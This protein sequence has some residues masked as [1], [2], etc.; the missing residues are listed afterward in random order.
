M[1]ELSTYQQKRKKVAKK[2]KS[3]D[4]NYNTL[5]IL[6]LSTSCP[7]NGVHHKELSKD[8]AEIELPV[9]KNNVVIEYFTML[10]Q[11][12]TYGCELVMAWGDV[13]VVVPV[14]FN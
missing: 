4:Y 11:N 12:S 7:K 9:I 10:F 1:N 6:T 13:K 3:Y 8:L 14:N 2:E 5:L